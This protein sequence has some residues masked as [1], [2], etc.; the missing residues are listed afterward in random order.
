[1]KAE[2]AM[3]RNSRSKGFGTVK[4]GSADDAN[5]AITELNESTFQ[6][7]KIVVRIDSFAA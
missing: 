6:G 4:M 7:R 2:V 5:N 3:D 1:V